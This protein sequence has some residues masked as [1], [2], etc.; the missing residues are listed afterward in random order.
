MKDRTRELLEELLWAVDNDTGHE[1]S[2]SVLARITAK[3][4]I[5]S[6]SYDRHGGLIPCSSECCNRCS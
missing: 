5:W 2:V 1:P 3:R 6:F 4:T